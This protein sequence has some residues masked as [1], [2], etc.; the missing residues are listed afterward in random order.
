MIY[1]DLIYLSFKIILFLANI[2]LK[3]KKKSK[4]T[5]HKISNVKF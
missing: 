3:I 4:Y 1:A 2:K 5:K